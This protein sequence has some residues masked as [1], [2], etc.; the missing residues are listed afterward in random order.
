M[1]FFDS[2]IGMFIVQSFLHS[3]VALVIIEIAFYSWEIRDHL[4]RF[5]YR[6]LVLTLPIFI[7]PVYQLINPDR[8]SMY[9]RENT[10]LFNFN[11]WLAIRMWDIIPLYALFFALLSG[12]ALIFF[13]QEILPI[14]RERLPKPNRRPYLIPQRDING[15]LED[16]CKKLGAAKPAVRVLD[17]SYP[18]LFTAGVKNHAIILSKALLEKFTDNQMEGALA[19]ELVHIIRGSGI[20][21]QIIYILR[22]LMFYNPV[23]LIEF[24]RLVQDDEFICD[25]ITVS[26]TKKPDALA[27]AISAFHSHPKEDKAAR[28]SGVKETIESHSHN[29]LLKERVLRIQERGVAES[30]EFGWVKFILTTLIILK[31]N[32]MVV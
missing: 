7:F 14:I 26:L 24:R 25:G 22:M 13:L 6:L 23:S 27:S 29:L 8:G 3:F 30:P 19:H 12:T 17:E 28:L 21:T 1:R 4:A 10:A 18:I 32:Y 15:M 20:K 31:I 5:R 16:L 9:F 11:K 2:Y